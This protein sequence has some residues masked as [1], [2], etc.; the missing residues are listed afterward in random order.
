MVGRTRPRSGREIRLDD[1]KERTNERTNE[2]TLRD[3]ETKINCGKSNRRISVIRTYG[4]RSFELSVVPPRRY[5]ARYRVCARW[6]YIRYVSRYTR[7]LLS[8]TLSF[9]STAPT[10]GLRYRAFFRLLVKIDSQTRRNHLRKRCIGHVIFRSYQFL[11]EDNKREEKRNVKD[12]T[13][14]QASFSE[15]R[16][17]SFRIERAKDLAAS[18]VVNRL[19]KTRSLLHTYMGNGWLKFSV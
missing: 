14:V 11:N 15:S 8:N 2:G 18:W 19:I 5:R 9:E 17:K 3:I 7:L 4:R 13:L 16:F 12:R 10:T 1:E 6:Y